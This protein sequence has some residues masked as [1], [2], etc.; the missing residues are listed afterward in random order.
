MEQQV[1]VSLRRISRERSRLL[2]AATESAK[3]VTGLKRKVDELTSEVVV[4]KEGS[5]CVRGDF[6]ALESQVE[7]ITSLELENDDL[8]TKVNTI[9]KR[10]RRLRQSKVQLDN[11]CSYES[12]EDKEACITKNVDMVI[13]KMYPRTKDKKKV[14]ILTRI[15]SAG[16]SFGGDGKEGYNIVF[17]GQARKNFEP[18]RVLQALDQ[19]SRCGNFS[20]TEIMRDME[21]LKKYERGVFRRKSAMSRVAKV[22]DPYA[23]DVVPYEW[24]VSKTGHRN[25]TFDNEA[26]LRHYLDPM[27]LTKK[28]ESGSV[29]IC[30]TLDFAEV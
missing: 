13:N 20:T 27:G 30:F 16:K 10:E 29:S 3:K 11:G 14:M 4:A 5:D 6:F 7:V 1:S 28:A 18:W 21:G 22:L 19:D 12:I 9:E 25:I 17:L 26:V 24:Y 8:K 2:R 23:E 15:M